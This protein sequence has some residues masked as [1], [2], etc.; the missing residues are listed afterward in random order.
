M[1]DSQFI[2]I[3]LHCHVLYVECVHV[4]IA[5]DHKDLIRRQLLRIHPEQLHHAS[6][7]V[8]RTVDIK[9][10][11]IEFRMIDRIEP[12]ASA[13]HGLPCKKSVFTLRHGPQSAVHLSDQVFVQHRSIGAGPPAR[14]L[15]V[16]V[17][18]KDYDTWRDLPGR[19]SLIKDL[20]NAGY[21]ERLACRTISMQHIYHRIT[22]R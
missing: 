3:F 20:R 18:W 11:G 22:I 13:S 6:G 2:Q 14:L 10:T 17:I 12:R 15:G 19:D 16:A 4:M 7:I 9:Y 1:R 8:Q 5:A 21:L